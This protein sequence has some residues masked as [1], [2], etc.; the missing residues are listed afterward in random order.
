[1]DGIMDRLHGGSVVENLRMVCT[2]KGLDYG[3]NVRATFTNRLRTVLWMSTN[4]GWYQGYRLQTLFTS[5]SR[6]EFTDEELTDGM[7]GQSRAVAMDAVSHTRDCPC[8][9][10]CHGYFYG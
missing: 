3:C 9:C 2:D 5:S 7:D 10:P 8:H 6:T 4:Y 1:M